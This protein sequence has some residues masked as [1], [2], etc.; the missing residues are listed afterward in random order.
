MKWPFVSAALYGK[1]CVQYE[2]LLQKELNSL[3]ELE[4][5]KDEKRKLLKHNKKLVKDLYKQRGKLKAIRN[6]LKI[7]D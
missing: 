1:L 3:S 2:R 5:A 7:K 6:I 4:E